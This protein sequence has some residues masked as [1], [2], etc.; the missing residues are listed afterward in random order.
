MA[1]HSLLLPRSDQQACYRHPLKGSCLKR[2]PQTRFFSL[3]KSAVL[4]ESRLRGLM[5]FVSVLTDVMRQCGAFSV[6]LAVLNV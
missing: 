5:L 3:S 6:H 4:T 2:E 1:Q